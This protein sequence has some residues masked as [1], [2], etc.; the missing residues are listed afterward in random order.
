MADTIT[1]KTIGGD[2]H[3][4]PDLRIP[5]QDHADRI[6]NA[7]DDPDRET[8]WLRFHV[9][10]GQALVYVPSITGVIARTAGKTKGF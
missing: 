3:I 6:I 1:I 4:T 8:D 2:I 9:D 7:I 10:R 5:V